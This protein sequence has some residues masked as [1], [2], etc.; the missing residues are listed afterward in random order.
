MDIQVF[1]L[2]IAAKGEGHGK[3]TAATRFFHMNRLGSSFIR[4]MATPLKEGMASI[5]RL[6]ER[7]LY[8]TQE[9]KNEPIPHWNGKTSRDILRFV[10]TD[11]F[12]DRLKEWDPEIGSNIWVKN[13]QLWLEEEGIKYQFVIIDDIRFPNEV[14]MVRDLGGYM[15]YI[16]NPKAPPPK[17]DHK[18][19]QLTWEDV[20]ACC[21]GRCTKIINNMDAEFYRD[22][23]TV[24]TGIGWRRD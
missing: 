20:V 4:P 3:T 9:N 7:Q 17:S 12:R 1:V 21:S 6:N 23:H 11:L 24:A 14:E 5:F 19:D 2:G 8:G 16:E 10:G 13:F 18:S 22:L 15:I